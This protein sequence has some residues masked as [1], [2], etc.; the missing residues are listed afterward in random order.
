MQPRSGDFIMEF[1][2]DGSAL[3]FLFEKDLVGEIA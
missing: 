1:T 2:T 3:L